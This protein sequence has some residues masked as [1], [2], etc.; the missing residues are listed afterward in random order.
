MNMVKELL[1]LTGKQQ[2]ELHLAVGVSQP[3]VSDWVNKKKNPSGENLRKVAEF[4]GVDWKVVKGLM[5]I[6]DLTPTPDTQDDDEREVWELREAIRRDPER[7]VLL[8]LAKNGT[9]QDVRQ[10]VALIDALRATNPDFYD[11]DDPS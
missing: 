7:M 9:A 5:P 8:K 3:T 1:D 2:K 6:P 11:G 4:F 10:A